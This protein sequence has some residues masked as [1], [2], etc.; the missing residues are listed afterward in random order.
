TALDVAN[1]I[2]N[3]NLDAPVGQVGQQPAPQGQLFQLPVDTLGRLTEP[4]RF[5]N[6]IV[7]VAQTV[8]AA[9]AT[10]SPRP[11]VGSIGVPSTSAT[12]IAR[13]SSGTATTGTAGG[14]ALMSNSVT[15]GGGASSTATVAP[16]ASTASNSATPSPSL[17]VTATG[18]GGASGGGTT[19]GGS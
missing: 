15:R 17:G 12:S 3:Q 16:A 10:G 2:R 6:I 13:A 5:A 4:E 1:A 18:G 8:P 9:Q 19:A 11:A 7:K 14:S